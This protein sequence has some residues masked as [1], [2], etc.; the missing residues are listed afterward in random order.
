[1]GDVYL[2]AIMGLDS[3]LPHEVLTFA[4]VI[5]VEGT[6]VLAKRLCVHHT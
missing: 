4:K 2:E 3:I 5:R 6:I 1:M